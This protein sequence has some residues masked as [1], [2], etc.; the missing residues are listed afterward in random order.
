MQQSTLELLAHSFNTILNAYLSHGATGEAVDIRAGMDPATGAYDERGWRQKLAQY[1]RT[2]QSAGH[3]ACALAI[4]I[5]SDRGG[6]G[7]T[8]AAADNAPLQ[9]AARTIRGA[10]FH[11][12][13]LARVDSAEFAVLAMPCEAAGARVI[14][15]RLEASLAA[16]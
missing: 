8:L 15:A 4:G 11:R 16:T 10:I 9:K 14:K 2:C 12:D 3:A 5:D 13:V 1:E 6:Q 7:T